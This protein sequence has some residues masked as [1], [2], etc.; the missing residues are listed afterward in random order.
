MDRPGGHRYCH[1][2]GS[3]GLS[4]ESGIDCFGSDGLSRAKHALF[5]LLERL[6]TLAVV[7]QL[8][9]RL[10]RVLGAS[11]GSNVRIYEAR[12][13]NLF[14][15]FSNLIIDDDVHVGPGVLIDLT[16]T[17]HLGRGAVVS[18]RCVIL[19]HTDVGESHQS[20]MVEV[21]PTDHAAVV[22]GSYSYVGASATILAG[23]ELGPRTAVAAGAVVTNSTTGAELVGG[24]PARHLKPLEFDR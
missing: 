9:A 11:I 21:F 18:P 3:R 1:D 23:V 12:F 5:V 14:E 4:D 15:G 2:V 16:D 7:P 8:R 13:F 17:V 24:L 22:I 10:L 6:L 20:P 19:T